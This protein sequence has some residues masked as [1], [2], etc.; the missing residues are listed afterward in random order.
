MRL[1]NGN[2]GVDGVKECKNVFVLKNMIKL[3]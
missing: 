1:V 2:D 3:N